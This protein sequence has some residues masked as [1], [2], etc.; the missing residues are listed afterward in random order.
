MG[1][2]IAQA[3]PGNELTESDMELLAACELQD[4]FTYNTTKQTPSPNHYELLL[5]EIS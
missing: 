4:P 2:P 3:P 1:L 5:N